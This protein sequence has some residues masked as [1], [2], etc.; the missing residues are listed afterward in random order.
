MKNQMIK[1]GTA[2]P[3]LKVADVSYN[4]D[5]ITD[6]MKKNRDCGILVFPELC[7]TGYTCADLFQQQLLLEAAESGLRRIAA[8]SEKLPGLTVIVGLPLRFENALYNAAAIVSEGVIAGIVPKINLPTYGEFYEQ[9]WF[10]S[11]R[12]LIGRTVEIAGQS[13]LFGID[14]LAEDRASG[15]VIGID[16]CEDLWVPDKPSTHACLA[17]A[18]II[19]NLSASDEVIGKQNYRRTMVSSQSAACYC[20]YLYASS[21][22]DESSTDLVFSGHC[23]I[24]EN[25]RILADSIFPKRPS[26]QTAV[27]DLETAAANRR[28]QN[29]FGSADGSW[30]RRTEVSVKPLGGK[31][32][33][34]AEQLCKS[35]RQESYQVAPNPFVPADD[36]ERGRRCRNILAIQAN[37]LATR[38]RAT[39]ISNLVIGVSGGLDSTLA[40]I[41]CAEA[42]KIV[43][44][45]HI[46]AYTLPNRG[47]TTSQTYTNAMNLMKYIGADEIHEVAIED[48]VKAHLQAIGHSEEYQGDGDTAYENA[49]ARMRT[50]I[51][52]DVAN[53]RN[54]LV[55]GT[56]D[57]SE[58][59]LG[60]CTYNG[61]HMSMYGV[62]ASVPKTLVQYICRSYA[63]TCGNVDLCRTLLA[64][65]DTPITPELTPSSNGRIAQKTEEKIGKYDL[66]DFFLFYTL[67]YGFEP[68][69]TLAFAE[70]AYPQAD[71]AGI[72]EAAERFFT[73]FFHQQFK[74]SC[75]PDGPKVGSVTLSPRGDWRMP[76]DAS[77]SL[78]LSALKAS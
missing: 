48:G 73:R 40:L 32:E 14:V 17:G 26:V 62:N 72:R 59:A 55:V 68:T 19:A 49:Q 75:L 42:K 7:I 69:K 22:M 34:S 52:M 10:A 38:V 18:N 51:L 28:H 3:A 57:L 53:M 21:G 4:V 9:R 58:L 65:C 23:L 76:S 15:A 45:I 56:G 2:V 41:V 16:V 11:G 71:P 46:L 50:Y 61:D 74:R 39:G 6:L 5:Q 78:W 47:N 1:A 36:E 30:Y 63:L 31:A 24:A 33:V 54:G 12:D 8:V 60:W 29:T 25:G 43:P 37:G 67:R 77:V 20:A 35:L 64:I 27:I 70:I 44:A 66:N 13:V